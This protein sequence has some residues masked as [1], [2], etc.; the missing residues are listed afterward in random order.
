MKAT[1]FG[2][3]SFGPENGRKVPN[4]GWFLSE[5]ILRNGSGDAV[6][7]S[8]DN[9]GSDVGSESTGY[10]RVF[11]G[12]G[13][14]TNSSGPKPLIPIFLEL[15]LLNLLNSTLGTPLHQH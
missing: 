10:N 12:L 6:M 9:H 8:G 1:H 15:Y 2:T 3:K 5:F 14:V 11:M 13:L 7:N 4:T